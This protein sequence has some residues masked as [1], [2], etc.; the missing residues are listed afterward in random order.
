MYIQRRQFNILIIS[1]NLATFLAKITGFDG[2]NEGKQAMA[3]SIFPCFII[4]RNL[5]HPMTEQWIN[6]E[7]IHV[8]QFIESLGL[9]WFYSKLEYLYFR[10]FKKYSHLEAYRNESIEQEAYLN[11]HDTE[12]LKKRPIFNT[13]LYMKIKTKFY[14]DDNYKVV[15]GDEIKG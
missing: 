4:L 12:Y 5:T 9:F 2:R 11:Q 15:V 3:F 6:H 14:T 7:S 1:D 8:R 10:L 13:I